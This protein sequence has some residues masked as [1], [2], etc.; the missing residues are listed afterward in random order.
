VTI[1]E[2]IRL[3]CVFLVGFGV[4]TLY[5]AWDLRQE[6]R[7]MQAQARELDGQTEQMKEFLETLQG[8][9]VPCKH[10]G[11]RN[12]PLWDACPY[13]PEGIREWQLRHASTGKEVH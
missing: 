3:V 13:C 10:C 7:R 8:D 1:P 2:A 12:P 4:S 6:A 11:H 5:H 9:W